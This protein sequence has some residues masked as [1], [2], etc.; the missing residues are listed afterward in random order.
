[1]MSHMDKQELLKRVSVDPNVAGGKPCIRGT[2][3]YVATILDGM[4]EGLT[5]EQVID[6]YPQLKLDDIR[7]A[8]VYGGE[9]AQENT[10]KLA[11]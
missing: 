6:H 8:L 10:W 5:P 3:I 7:A 11:V 9:L 4:A 1:M 2:R